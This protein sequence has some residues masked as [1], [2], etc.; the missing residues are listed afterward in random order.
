MKTPKRK[1]T[2][3]KCKHYRVTMGGGWCNK[4]IE[5]DPSSVGCKNYAPND[6]MKARWK[7]KN[8]EAQFK[9]TI[10]RLRRIERRKLRQ[11]KLLQLYRARVSRLNWEIMD[12]QRDIVHEMDAATAWEKK[13]YRLL[14]IA[15]GYCSASTCG[16]DLEGS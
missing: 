1:T 6:E 12:A 3:R 13:Y 5:L 15:H 4:T 14:H 11:D 2:C 16:Q 9:R 8:R 10:A 7:R